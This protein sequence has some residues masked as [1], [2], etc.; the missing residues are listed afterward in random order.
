[1]DRVAL[2]NFEAGRRDV[3][4]ALEGLA[5][6]DDLFKPSAKLLLSLAEAENE[7]WS[8]NATGVFARTYLKIA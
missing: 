5:L 1:M 7:T 3:I 2:L 8:N 4:W 6:Y